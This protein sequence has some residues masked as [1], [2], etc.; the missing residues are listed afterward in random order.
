[1]Q[2]VSDIQFVVACFSA[3][4][5][6]PILREVCSSPVVSILEAPLLLASNLGGRVGIITTSRRWEFLLARDV[7]AVG[8][9]S[10]NA[11][12]VVSSGMLTSELH[13]LPL[14]QVRQT[15]GQVAL[16]RLVNQ[17]QADV[18]ILGCAGMA[19]LEDAIQD[20]CQG[21]TVLDPVKCGLE[22]AIGLVNIKAKT[23]KTGIYMTI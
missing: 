4:P 8:L 6:V 17:R 16:D 2:N 20:A 15:L 5:L 3:H 22:I 10:L 9:A 7:A 12:G 13:D 21:V 14:A 23:S 1:M 11:A 18:I 19:G